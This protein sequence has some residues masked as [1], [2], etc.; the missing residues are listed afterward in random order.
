[1]QRLF[2]VI[3]KIVNQNMTYFLGSMIY[4]Y[5]NIRNQNKGVRINGPY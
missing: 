4:N 5:I 1:M 2:K 3:I